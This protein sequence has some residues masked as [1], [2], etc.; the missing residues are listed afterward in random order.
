MRRSCAAAVAVVSLAVP[1]SAQ[2]ASPLL[3]PATRHTSFDVVFAQ[4]TSVQPESSPQDDKEKKDDKDKKKKETAGSSNDRLFWALPNFLT[5]ENGKQVPPL[6]TG[7]K[8][9]E[10]IRESFDYVDYA[11]YG[12]LA[13]LSQANNGDAGYGRGTK[14]YIKRYSAEFAD[15]TIENIFTSAVFPVLLH[16]DPR[17]YQ[18]GTG[19]GLRRM[20]YSISRTVVTRTDDGH[21]RFNYSE[22][23]GSGLAAVLSNAYHASGD[24]G[25]ALTMSSWWGLV[26]YDTGQT[27]VREF[28]PDIH[29]K[30]SKTF[31]KK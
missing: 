28:W 29:R 27:V 23:L 17:Y 30:I 8:Y 6:T 2:Q 26:A 18:M 10:A 22:I 3:E 1:A 24:R 12:F 19:G 15:G 4:Q 14:G 25:V 21:E 7:Q 11:W 16:E 13:E 5:V 31:H 20:G 9:H